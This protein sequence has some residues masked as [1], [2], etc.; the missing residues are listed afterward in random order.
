MTDLCR[1]N[2]RKDDLFIFDD[3]TGKPTAALEAAAASVSQGEEK[4]RDGQ[5]M[6]A[7]PGVNA[8]ALQGADAR[9]WVS[10]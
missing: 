10:A 2:K 7:F 8:P 1:H 3:Q 6:V 4:A 9:L 5:E